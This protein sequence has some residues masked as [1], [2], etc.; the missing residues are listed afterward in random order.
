MSKIKAVMSGIRNYRQAQSEKPTFRGVYCGNGWDVLRNR[1]F[2]LG[3]R[4]GQ[5]ILKKYIGY[6]VHLSEFG[7]VEEGN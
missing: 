2:N 6:G 7:H 4:N 1:N 3:G 5:D